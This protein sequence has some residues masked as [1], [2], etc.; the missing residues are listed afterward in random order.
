[1]GGLIMRKLL[2]VLVGSL[3]IVAL[4][5]SAAL[6]AAN[7]TDRPWK[8]SGS[9]DGIFTPGTPATFHVDGT[10]TNA[11]LGRST[12]SVDGVCTNLDCSASTFTSTIVAANGDTLTVSGI[13]V[14]PGT[15]HIT[16]TGGTG[17]FVG[18]SG[19]ATNTVTSVVADPANP[20]ASHF[21]FRQRGTISY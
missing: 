21:T 7:G 19:T 10:S 9:G 8:A 6:G 18:A 15:D 1:M 13:S 5:G 2:V 11:H 12:F 14:G 16:F 3:L 17:R 20:L 4:S